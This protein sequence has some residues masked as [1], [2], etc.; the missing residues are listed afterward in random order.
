ETS[1]PL[2]MYCSQLCSQQ[3]GY[4]LYVPEPQRNLSPLYRAAGVAIGD[5]GMVTPEGIW[6]FC[7]NIFL[8]ADHAIHQDGVPNDFVPL[9]PCAES[10]VHTLDYEAGSFVSSATVW[11]NDPAN[12]QG[13]PG[14]EFHFTCQAPKGAL[15]ALPFGSQ[16]KKLAKRKEE[17]RRYAAKNAES[18]YRYINGT[19]GRRMANGEL[20]LITGSEKT[21]AG[22]MATF[23]NL[24]P[25]AEFSLAFKP[26]PETTRYYF[27]YA[28]A[29]T[30][31][32]SAS[33]QDGGQLTNTVFLH[34]FTISLG[35]GILGQLFA[36]VGISQISDS[37]SRKTQGKFFPFCD[38][39]SSSI[40]PLSLNFFT[41]GGGGGD[42]GTRYTTPHHDDEVTLSELS[43]A[44][45][46]R[47]CVRCGLD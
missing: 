6:D 25:G 10:D 41:G 43:A 35:E 23:Q 12:F 11:T 2:E 17:I 27:N 46:V 28:R 36:N 15:L 9:E 5:V 18:W 16:L 8:P 40:F 37:Q 20:Y 45:K 14:G 39:G 19:T 44:A 21:S 24:S 29:Q 13:F 47:N 7:F 1:S 42:S 30:K 33:E 26:F 31:T 32:F 34:G 3:R 38:Q 4:P 22:G